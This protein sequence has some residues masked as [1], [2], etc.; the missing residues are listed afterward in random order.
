MSEVIHQ[1]CWEKIIRTQISKKLWHGTILTI[2]KYKGDEG[3]KVLSFGS[4]T[5][6]YNYRISET[7]SEA[8]HVKRLRSAGDDANFMPGNNV[9]W[10]TEDCTK[11]QPASLG[12]ALV[13][14]NGETRASVYSAGPQ[15]EDCPILPE[16]YRLP[17][18]GF[19]HCWGGWT[20]KPW[21]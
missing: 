16:T 21:R 17:Q 2:T 12:V 7:W 6:I 10:L 13:S 11:S 18:R 4:K 15:V 5:P 20:G 14:S 19:R 1:K 8:I 3:K 9:P